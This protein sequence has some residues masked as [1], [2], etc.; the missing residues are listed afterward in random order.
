MEK[1]QF[2]FLHF[3]MQNN[4]R[5]EWLAKP[6][7]G[8]TV[9]FYYPLASLKYFILKASVH[10]FKKVTDVKIKDL[11]K[12]FDFTENYVTALAINLYILNHF[13]YIQKR[14]LIWKKNWR[15]IYIFWLKPL[16]FSERNS[17]IL[18]D[19]PLVITFIV[20]FNFC[21]HI[22]CELWSWF[23]Q[24]PPILYK[25]SIFFAFILNLRPNVVG[26]Y[27]RWSSP[28]MELI[29]LF[30]VVPFA[31][32]KTAFMIRLRYNYL[33]ECMTVS[34]PLRGMEVETTGNSVVLKKYRSHPINRHCIYQNKYTS[35]KNITLENSYIYMNNLNITAKLIYYI[36]NNNRV[37]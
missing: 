12:F 37:T 27:L 28:R 26:I 13:F 36:V 22:V 10:N 15:F 8:L 5:N 7:V 32:N 25:F 4:T 21:S 2:T 14:K 6:I 24:F 23:L 33:S 31:R 19:F 29:T 20:F 35:W 1:L 34:W 17:Y 9:I 16:F 3:L 11:E 18:K 30:D